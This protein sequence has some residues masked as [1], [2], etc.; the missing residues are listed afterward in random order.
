MSGKILTIILLVVAVISGA[1]IYWLQVYG[2]YYDAPENTE[3]QLV[4]IATGQG[5]T[6]PVDDFVGIDADT[7]PLRFRACFTMPFSQALLSETYQFYQGA[8]PLIAP[9]WFECF[10]AAAIGADLEQ[11]MA[12]AFL[13]RTGIDKVADQVIAVYPDGR[14]FAWNQLNETYAE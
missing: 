11:G 5:E 14:A 9:D 1:A 8:T 6:I 13:G 3:I 10:D 2:Y 12:L 4:N 7:S